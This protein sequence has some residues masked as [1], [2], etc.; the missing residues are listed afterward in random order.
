[1]KI[2]GFNKRE[3]RR[4]VFSWLCII[5]LFF[6]A[7]TFI[8]TVSAD[9]LPCTCG[10]ICVDETGW[11]RAGA[12]YNASNTPIQHAINNATAG[13]TICVKDGTYSEN[14]D[15]NKRLTI[16]SENGTANC[17]VNAR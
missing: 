11:W 7:L 15:V 1:M 17:I 10:D 3:K 5:L 6:V 2:S 14:V 4:I 8:A 9:E 13:N 12:D 16:R